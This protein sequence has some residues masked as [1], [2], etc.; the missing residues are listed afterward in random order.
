MSPDAK[1]HPGLVYGIVLTLLSAAGCQNTGPEP[2]RTAEF[3]DLERF[4]GDWYVVGNI[5]TPIE[6]T[7][8]NAVERYTLDDNGT[9]ATTFTFNDK[10]FDGV[11][12]EY[13]PR[14]FVRDKESNAVWGMQFIWPIKA[15]YRIL[16]VDPDYAF[17]IVGRTARDYAWIMARSPDVP[18][19][20][21]QQ[22]VALLADEAYDVS[23][24][25]RVPHRWG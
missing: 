3:V 12:K 16:Y 20:V 25:R 11:R 22:L 8:F 9:I 10:A 24:V 1:R 5:P 18:E 23:K 19:D 14:A 15:E 2:I 6:K 17:T 7:A 21:Y 4:M 13:K